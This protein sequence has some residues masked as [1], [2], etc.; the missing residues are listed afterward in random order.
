MRI[1]D[2]F[3]KGG[4]ILRLVPN[5]VPRRFSEA[6]RRLRLHPDDYYALGTQRGSIK[7][8]W[9]SSVIAAM[10]G[11]LAPPDE[12]MSYVA[13][14]DNIEDKF[15]FKD[16]VDELG[17]DIIGADLHASYGTWPMYS[18]FFDYNPPL[19]FHLHLDDEAA[20][21]VG[22]IGKPEAYYFPPQLNNHPGQFPVTYFGIDPLITK[23][24]VRAR[25]LDFEKCD[26]RITELSRAFRI[27]LGTGWYT[28][29][30]VLHA[31][32]SYL[33]YEPQWNSDVNSVYENVTAGEV[34][35]YEFLVENVPEAKK[36]D[37]DYVLSFMDWDANVDP[38][39][40][41]KYFRPPLVC[42]HSDEQHTEKWVVYA[43][44]YIAAKELTIQPGATVTVKDGAAYG[45]ILVQGHGTFGVYE[46]EAAIMLRFGQLSA[47]EYFVSEAAAKAGVTI[48]N[49]SQWEP[50]VIL[51]HFGPNHPDMPMT[52]PIVKEA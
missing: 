50:M 14:S 51:K 1:R 11:P 13:P 29:P 52:V 45:C 6:G 38:L 31:P 7:E 48:T 24:E 47:D 36:R 49:H 37:V 42:D 39:Y 28:P 9:F 8:R 33:T 32:G 10:N 41:Q 34:Y 20:A 25:L 43:N 40:Y 27:R 19:F 2:T 26:T 16:A 21:R 18:K 3:E 22:R 44:D 46:A 15:L 5:F 30:G 35:P 17:A 12:G 23:D 4:G